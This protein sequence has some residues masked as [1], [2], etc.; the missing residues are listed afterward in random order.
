MFRFTTEGVNAS[1]QVKV[2]LPWNLNLQ[3]KSCV[4]LETGH[5]GRECQCQDYIPKDKLTERLS[6]IEDTYVNQQRTV[7]DHE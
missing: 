7:N 6:A 5:E 4:V 3:I 2:V 1:T